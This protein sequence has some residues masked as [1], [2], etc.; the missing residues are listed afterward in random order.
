M[1][2]HIGVHVHVYGLKT[3]IGI[4]I[5]LLILVVKTMILKKAKLFTILA[6]TPME[7]SFRQDSVKGCPNPLEI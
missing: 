4:F 7:Q 6:K 3:K 5:C 1:L 2:I